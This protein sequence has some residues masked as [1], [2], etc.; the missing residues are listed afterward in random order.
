MV[1]LVEDGAVASIASRAH[2]GGRLASSDALTIGHVT[3]L[4]GAAGHSGQR[5]AGPGALQ[6]PLG[7][8][9]V[10]ARDFDVD[11]V[12][13]RQRD[14]ILHGQVKHAGSDQAA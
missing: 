5:S 1:A 2:A 14:G 3:G 8:D 4:S 10:V 12:F 13:E 11:I 9:R 7:Q 6:L